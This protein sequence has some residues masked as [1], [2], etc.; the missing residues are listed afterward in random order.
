M[1]GVR[2][3][4]R[5]NGCLHAC[6]RI[7]RLCMNE[8]VN[9]CVC[10]CVLSKCYKPNTAGLPSYEIKASPS[11]PLRLQCNGTTRLKLTHVVGGKG[12]GGGEGEAL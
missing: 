12:R 8:L 4:M 3:C 5:M 10:V 2:A 1:D 11:I 9:V 6:V 7:R